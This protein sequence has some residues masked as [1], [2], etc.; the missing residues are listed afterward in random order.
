MPSRR[1]HTKSRLGCVQ[2][3]AR[4]V[5][6]DIRPNTFL[7]HP[8]L[9]DIYSAIKL[10]QHVRTAFDMRRLVCTAKSNLALH[11]QRQRPRVVKL[12]IMAPQQQ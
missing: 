1:A 4:R 6:V 8:M 2:C 5:K 9:T 11:Q 12:R 7:L 10:T 3:K